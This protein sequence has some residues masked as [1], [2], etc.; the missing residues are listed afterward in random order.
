M[1]KALITFLIFIIA[2]VAMGQ[3]F[4]PND[5]SFWHPRNGVALP[6]HGSPA[7]ITSTIVTNST[8][9]FQFLTNSV[10]VPSGASFPYGIAMVNCKGASY[11]QA[12][13]VYW[14]GT[15]MTLLGATNYYSGVAAVGQVSVWGI[16]SNSISAGTINV[17][18][19][20]SNTLNG[21]N[22]TTLVLTNTFGL[23]ANVATSTGTPTIMGVTNTITTSPGSPNYDM[24]LDDLGTGGITSVPEAGI[25]VISTN[26]LANP[27]LTADSTNATGTTTIVWWTNSVSSRWA[28]VSQ[29]IHGH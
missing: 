16:T 6:Y 22:L 25:N 13:N 19:C 1:M 11:V 8:T 18:A 12:T 24:V 28:Y 21:F 9:T 3:A 29:V 15:A 4:G 14:N 2:V 20:V 27:T 17:I 7:V 23:G 26:G 5:I 10:T